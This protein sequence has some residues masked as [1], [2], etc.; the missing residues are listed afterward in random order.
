MEQ[1]MRVIE[2][3]TGKGKRMRGFQE[4]SGQVLDDLK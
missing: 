2:E 3:K 1:S 4:A